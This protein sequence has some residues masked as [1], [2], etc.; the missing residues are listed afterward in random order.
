MKELKFTKMVQFKTNKLMK[1]I[2]KNA[3]KIRKSYTFNIME[4]ENEI[5]MNPFLLSVKFKD[6]SQKMQFSF[7]PDHPAFLFTKPKAPK[8]L[9]IREVVNVDQ[10]CDGVVKRNN[11]KILMNTSRVDSL[12]MVL[13]DYAKKSIVK[14]LDDD[15]NQN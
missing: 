4:L 12:Y 3:Q 7:I 10:I 1:R 2:I 6:F 5:V 8:Y 14:F 13:R 9:L 15:L 11:E